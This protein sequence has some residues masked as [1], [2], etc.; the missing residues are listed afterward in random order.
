[1]K[2]T[3]HGWVT[4][5]RHHPQRY[6]AFCISL[7]LQVV[8]WKTPWQKNS[9]HLPATKQ[10][11]GAILVLNSAAFGAIA[12]D[13]LIIYIICTVLSLWWLLCTKELKAKNWARKCSHLI[14]LHN[15]SIWR[16][17]FV[18]Q[19]TFS[20]TPVLRRQANPTVLS[21]LYNS[22]EMSA[23][24]LEKSIN[25]TWRWGGSADITFLA[26]GGRCLKEMFCVKIVCSR[27]TSMCL[28]AKTFINN[29]PQWRNDIW[30]KL[31]M[32]SLVPEGQLT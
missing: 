28:D 1:M 9:I 8:K 31:L 14:S 32:C 2:F 13:L 27:N 20:H 15:R 10:P 16:Q 12:I 6:L 29:T 25:G 4:P 23:S 19:P 7:V 24:A 17:H 3:F 5:I 30:W 21:A 26:Y 22:L 18:V 11:I